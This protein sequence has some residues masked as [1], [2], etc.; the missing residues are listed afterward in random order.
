MTRR[1]PLRPIVA[2]RRLKQACGAAALWAV[3]FTTTG[4]AQPAIQFEDVTA[5]AGL[6]K[7][8]EGMMGHGGAWGDVDG[9]GLPDLFVG[10]FCDRP[11]EEYAPAKAQ[12][13]SR[14]FHNTGAGFEEWQPEATRF[15]GRVSGALFADLDNNGTLELYSANNARANSRHTDEVRRSA[16]MRMS[17]LFENKNGKLIDISKSSGACPEGLRSARNIGALDYNAD[18]LLDLLVVEDKF[19]KNPRTLLLKNLGDLKFE[20]ANDEVGL[21]NDIFALG[22]AYSDINEDGRPD[23]FFP[24]S[25]RMFLSTGDGKYRED[26]KLNETFAWK[27]VNGEEWP[28]GA[29][30]ADLNR[31]GRLDLLLSLHY[32]QAR[33]KVYLNEGLKNGVPQFRDV[34]D[35]VGLGE[36][37]PQ[38]CPHV[39][40][41]DFDNDGNPD[42]YMSAAWLD[43]AGNVTPLIYRNQG[44]KNG[45]PRFVP[46]RAIEGPMV[47]YP[48]GPSADYDND[49]KVDLFLINWFQGNHSRLLRNTSAAGGWLNVRV[50]GTKLNRMG[51]G[52]KVSLYPAGK[53][54]D[55]QA[56]LG[57]QELT[58]G[59]GYASGQ[60][61]VC[62]FGL[63]DVKQVDVQ[64]TLPDGT[65]LVKKNVAADQEIKLVE[66]AK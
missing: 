43:D 55:A 36:T 51:I 3:A 15:H 10:G 24:H 30:F 48:A 47:Y 38:K 17:N 20:I 53:L 34:T 29:V 37:V 60:E 35:A 31:D 63:G 14:L 27:P 18:G 45:L 19:I 12:V 16:Q 54:G 33:N 32:Q 46:T 59:Y 41:Q 23:F 49:G 61:P 50:E 13:P 11:V 39:E 4:Q 1:L 52:S 42:I 57:H 6:L 64:V 44:L 56:L 58:V 7:P 28:C 5:K 22:L 40:V 65:Q 2:V 62:H 9:D 21:P 26:A 25:N 66:A 8:L